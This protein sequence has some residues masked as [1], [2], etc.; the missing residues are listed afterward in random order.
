MHLLR[1]EQSGNLYE[2]NEAVDLGQSPGRVVFLTAADTEINLL[3][4]A[5]E[6]SGRGGDALRLANILSLSHPYSVD[7]YIKETA[8]H[9]KALVVRLLG[10]VSYW[11]YGIER[12]C[13]VA[14]ERGIPLAL[15]AGDGKDDP[16]L[17]RLSTVPQATLEELNA[18]LLAGGSDN[19]SAFLDRIDDIIDGTSKALPPKPIL[20]AGIYWR[21]EA[22][23]EAKVE[24]ETDLAYL[25]G[26]W[27]EHN[28]NPVVALVFY[29]ALRQAGDTEAIDAL[30]N[31]LIAK[32]LA[33]L[34]IFVTSLKDSFS[35]SLTAELLKATDTSLILNTTS[36]ATARPLSDISLDASCPEPFGA[37]DAPV[38]QVILSSATKESW[39]ES[40][41]GLNPRDLAMHIVLPEIDGRIATR[42]IGFKAP[43]KR[44]ALTESMVTYLEA[45]QERADFV[46]ELARRWVRLATKKRSEKKLGLIMANYPNKD[47]R[48]ANGVG[49]DTPASIVEVLKHLKKEG[50]DTSSPDSSTELM[51]SVLQAPTNKGIEGRKV[52]AW[53]E[54]K[55]YDE[56]FAALPQNLRDAVTEQWGEPS[57][58]PM[59]DN[60]KG[61]ALPI[62]FYGNIVVAV[63]PQR[64]YGIDPKATYHS[65]LLPP[66][67]HYLAFYFW[68][69]HVFDADAVIHLGKH[70]NL[71]WLP[72]KALALSENCFPDAILGAVPHFYPFIVNDPGE[73]AQAKRRSAAVILDHLT[74]PLTLAESHS[75]MAEIE[76]LMD[77]YFEASGLDN[78]RSE[79]L[80]EEILLTAERAKLSDDCG[81]EPSDSDDEKLLK[82]DNFICDLK[83]MQIRDGLHVFGVSPKGDLKADLLAAI[84]RIPRGDG[85]GKG[86]SILRS[87]AKDLKLEGF[88]PL[89]AELGKAWQGKKPNILKDLMDSPWRNEGDGVERLNALASSLIKGEISCDKNW[90]ETRLIL[91]ETL[92][93]LADAIKRCGADELRFL[94]KGLDGGYVPASPAGAPTRG[95]PEVLPTGRNFYSIDSRAVPTETAWRIGWNSANELLERH[96]QDHGNYPRGVVLSAWG[97]A[98]MRT[99]GDDIA[100][101]LA[102]MGVRPEWDTTSRRVVGFEILPQEILARPRVDVTLRCSGFFRDAFPQQIAL[103]D[104]AARAVGALNEDK[105]HNPIAHRMK[106]EQSALEAKG[107]DKETAALRAGFRVFSAKPQS[108]GTG[109]QTLIDEG[110]WENREDFAEIF[111]GWGSYA[112]GAENEG[113]PAREQLNARLGSVDAIIHNQDNREHDL[114]DSDD[115]YQFAGGLSAAVFALSGGDVPVYMGDTSLAERPKIRLLS[116]EITRVVRGRVTNPKWISGV[117]RHG[118]KGAFEMAAS[119]D[120]LFAFAATTRQ[121]PSHL[122]DAVFEA[123]IENDEVHR[124]LK[125]ANPHA[126]KEMLERFEEAI[127]R[128][129]WQPRRN[130]TIELLAPTA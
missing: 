117:M 38:L 84:L 24:A 67:H 130:I 66:P 124:F 120:Y 119:L 63:Q 36:F 103:I 46:A 92:P 121:V 48:L 7:L 78:R 99:G 81:I 71:E 90:H 112:Y 77:E 5:A 127:E 126:L 34:P 54:R 55:K 100:Q 110:I 86:E 12:L 47:G 30:I 104:K 83:M 116:E 19:A 22:E 125:E 32:G 115:Y 73:G 53:L 87:L 3:A 10:G 4:R 51:A 1:I 16:E 31:A 17:A 93:P 29:R 80:M 20:G 52:E 68:L 128:G 18:Y 27:Q 28:L 65:P 74:P 88:D 25:R 101:A 118:Y 44:H 95:R 62:K 72:G 56:Y 23:T 98:N 96:V 21:G 111:L 57:A 97:T 2:S 129:L 37:V 43:P 35:S 91:D 106:E 113:T 102:L 13:S 49:L 41:A 33:P 85:K 123:W 8:C 79:T 82:L 114:L 50:Y 11:S 59:M 105:A 60:K 6:Q 64:G 58:D 45:H 9:A 75:A 40:S 26:K 69:R 107:L 70:G 94:I 109:I 76:A 14:E 15:L 122:F 42:A 108:Y 89:T 61:F 39:Q